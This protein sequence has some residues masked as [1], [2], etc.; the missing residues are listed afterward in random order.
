M[1][2]FLPLLLMALLFLVSC[3][4]RC[5]TAI[6]S[7]MALFSLVTALSSSGKLCGSC[8]ASEVCEACATS[9]NSSYLACLIAVRKVSGQVFTTRS[10][11]DGLRPSKNMLHWLMVGVL[12]WSNNI[13]KASA[14]AC[15]D[16][17]CCCLLH[18]NFRAKACS[19]SAKHCNIAAEN[20]SQDCRC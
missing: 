18:L 11:K 13:V 19:F 2:R 10:F 15:T 7:C 6:R 8:K 5:K 17:C 16:L 14:Y 1:S 20:W 3:L 12:V 9:W 4:L